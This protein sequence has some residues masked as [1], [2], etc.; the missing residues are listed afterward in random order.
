[1]SSTSS[2]DGAGGGAGAGELEVAVVGGA[3]GAGEGEEGV[4]PLDP[5][6]EGTLQLDPHRRLHDEPG[7]ARDDDA[8]GHDDGGV[9]AADD[10]RARGH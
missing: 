9:E 2:F 5:V 10:D 3:V 7:A 1:M 6:G 8:R 4:L